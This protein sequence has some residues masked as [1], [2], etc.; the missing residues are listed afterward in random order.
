VRG[1]GSLTAEEVF[2][3]DISSGK[4]TGDLT[5]RTIPAGQSPPGIPAPPAASSTTTTP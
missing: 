1:T 3:G 5:A 2:L 4:G